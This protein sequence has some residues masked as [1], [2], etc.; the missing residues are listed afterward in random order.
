[1]SEKRFTGE[2]EFKVDSKGRVSIPAK[3]RAVLESQDSE[4]A[5]GK[6]ARM[7]A[8][9]GGHLDNHVECY[10]A[11][12]MSETVEMIL[13]LPQSK[14]RTKL[15]RRWYISQSTEFAIDDTGRIV[16]PAK[17]REK[18]GV[19]AGETVLFAGVGKTF[20]I[21]RPEAYDAMVE[22]QEALLDDEDEDFDP[23]AL[24]D[25]LRAEAQARPHLSV[26]PTEE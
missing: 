21:W 2:E 4:Y 20:Q 19:G 8:V 26:V 15:M 7:Y 17:L 24:L 10:S 6:T 23:E 25:D 13:R 1:M 22:E 5:P 16:L 3:F 11:E 14:P 12:T 9:F 18:I